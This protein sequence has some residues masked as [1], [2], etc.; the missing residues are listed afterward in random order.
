MNW[1]IGHLFRGVLWEYR[2]LCHLKV[3]HPSGCEVLSATIGQ[4]ES[5]VL[6]FDRLI[7]NALEVM[8]I[9]KIIVKIESKIGNGIMYV[10]SHKQSP[11]YNANTEQDKKCRTERSYK[12]LITAQKLKLH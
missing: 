9:S 2:V 3:A 1:P 8:K 6:C 11:M 5:I 7:E 4:R 12:T 10:Y